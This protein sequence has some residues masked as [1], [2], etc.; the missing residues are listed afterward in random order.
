M[1]AEFMEFATPNEP[2]MGTVSFVQDKHNSMMLALIDDLEDVIVTHREQFDSIS[3]TCDDLYTR[4]GWV[5]LEM[6]TRTER[7]LRLA[8]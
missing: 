8:I 1:V 3:K 5:D 7:I 4:I 6:S 2:Q